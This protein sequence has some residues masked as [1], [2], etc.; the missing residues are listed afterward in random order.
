M[1]NRQFQDR[2][3]TSE[4]AHARGVNSRLL[5]TIVL[6]LTILAFAA[7]GFENAAISSVAY[8]A[9]YAF[10][11][12]LLGLTLA[13]PSETQSIGGAAKT[14][15]PARLLIG[16]SWVF[17]AFAA[18]STAWSIAPRETVMQTAVL[19]LLVANMHAHMSRRWRLSKPLLE[20]VTI[21]FVV[22]TI[23]M[24]ISVS[25]GALVGGRL[26]GVYSNPNTLGILAAFTVALGLGVRE[27]RKS[28][29][30]IS[31]GI[32]IAISVV[33]MLG[34]LSRTASLA[35]VAGLVVLVS[36]KRTFPP[37]VV[38]MA[39]FAGAGVIATLLVGRRIPFPAVMERFV[40][41]D[42]GSQFSGREEIWHFAVSLW[43]QQPWL[44]YG[45]RTGEIAFRRAGFS[46]GAAFNSYLQSLLEVGVLGV[47]PLVAMLVALI[48]GLMRA[49]SSVQ[50][51]LAALVAVGLLVC[52]TES[53][54]LGLGHPIA[55]VFWLCGGALAASV[56]SQVETSEGRGGPVLSPRN[57]ERKP[58]RV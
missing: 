48:W 49:R 31:T 51:G 4:R 43:E 53:S 52:L 20:D 44:G 18:L 12:L 27:G 10:A 16:S 15:E 55:W 21:I 5:R 34:T 14:S 23:T 40:S 26:S 41:P 36:R 9:R 8:V 46:G 7:A 24:V 57:L 3:G 42:G 19:V 29:F 50:T 35:L 39:S 1:T 13:T 33:A 45:F 32:A 25:M 47:L 58:E 38:A 37:M 28:I 54:L 6:G 56:E 17:V 11:A 22:L 2:R 30:Q